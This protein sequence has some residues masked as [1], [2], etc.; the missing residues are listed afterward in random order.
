[1]VLKHYYNLSDRLLYKK[2]FEWM[3]KG[4]CS[5]VR[6]ELRGFFP[7]STTLC[8]LLR[9]PFWKTA[10]EPNNKLVF[11]VNVFR[12]V[13]CCSCLFSNVVAFIRR[14]W[15]FRILTQRSIPISVLQNLL[16]LIWLVSHSELF[17]L[18][19]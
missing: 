8:K 4:V 13:S 1:M 10:Y 18:I 5:G 11:D 12:I 9:V 19:G 14:L 17:D 6:D 7:M 2:F 15:L 16:Q 3:W